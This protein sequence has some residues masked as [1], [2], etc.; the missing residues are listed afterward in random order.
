MKD[1][2]PRLHCRLIDK[3]N[4]EILLNVLKGMHSKSIRS[5]ATSKMEELDL[6]KILLR[7]GHIYSFDVTTFLQIV[8]PRSYTMVF[9]GFF[10]FLEIW[11]VSFISRD[12]VQYTLGHAYNEW[13]DL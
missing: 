8:S 13:F 9:T 5:C 11:G 3:K 2:S 4:P 7:V 12:K 10:N 1:N 6:Q